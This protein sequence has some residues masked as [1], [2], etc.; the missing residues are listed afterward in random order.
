MGISVRPVTHADFD[1]V[2]NLVSV[3]KGKPLDKNAFENTFSKNL[4]DSN[5][6]Y[7][8]AE[9]EDTI[10]GFIS[11]HIQHILHHSHITGELQELVI[12]PDLRGSGIGSILLTEVEKIARSLNLEEIELTTRTNREKAQAFYKKQGYDHTHNKFVKKLYSPH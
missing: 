3:L 11:L 10:V 8:V 4:S 7:I 5:I 9:K 2:Y 6:H 12:A 1:S